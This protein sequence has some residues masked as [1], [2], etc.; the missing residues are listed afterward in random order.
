MA[1]L[2]GSN[3]TDCRGI[4]INSELAY[5]YSIVI[6][7]G[8]KMIRTILGFLLVFGAAGGLDNA[9]DAQLLPLLAVTAVGLAL[10]FSGVKS[11][12]E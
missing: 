10:M 7:K 4:D 9:S 2:V 12:K 3:P 5:N 11:I 1:I 6:E 8:Y